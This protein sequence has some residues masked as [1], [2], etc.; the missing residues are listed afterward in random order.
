MSCSLR[1]H[2]E[3]PLVELV[4]S[5]HLSSLSFPLDI[6]VPQF[7]TAPL[8]AALSDSALV[9]LANNVEVS[10]PSGFHLVG[11]GD[12]ALMVE[13]V[14]PE[15]GGEGDRLEALLEHLHGSRCV[16]VSLL[17]V[18]ELLPVSV[19]VGIALKELGEGLP[20]KRIV[21]ENCKKRCQRRSRQYLPA[22]T[23]FL[24]STCCNR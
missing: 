19:A 7:V 12:G 14:D 10:R 8:T 17:E 22:S 16:P 2:L 23:S 20:A 1:G 9:G 3:D 13:E 21:S 6:V 4:D 11:G 24:L 18:A 15:V 5:R